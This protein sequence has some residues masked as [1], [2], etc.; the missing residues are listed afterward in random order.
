MEAREFRENWEFSWSPFFGPFEKTT[1]IPPVRFTNCT[2]VPGHASLHDSLQIFSVRIKELRR[3]LQWPIHVFG[4]IAARDTIDQNRIIVFN[5]TRDN[6]Q[7]LTK[8]DRYLSLTGPT[9]AV[10]ATDNV[11]LEAVLKVK[12][13]IESEDK[14]LSFLTV[15]LIRTFQTVKTC[16]VNREYTSRLSTMELTFGYVVHS[17]EAAISVHVID[18]LW[19]DGYRGLFA[20]H[21]FSLKDSKVVLLDCGY[22]EMVPVNADGRIG[23]SRHVVSVESKGD[24]TVSVMA[25]G[26]DDVKEDAK[27]FTPKDAGMSCDVLDVGFCK[28]EVTVAWSLISLVPHEYIAQCHSGG[29]EREAQEEIQMTEKEAGRKRDR[30]PGEG[31]GGS[32]DWK[33]EER[34][35]AAVARMKQKA[36]AAEWHRK[37]REESLKEME[38]EMAKY[39][40][41]A[42]IPPV[43]YTHCKD[44]PVPRHI[45]LRHTLQIISV[46]VKGLRRGLQW[47]INVFGLIAARDT[48]DRNRIMIFDRTRDNCQT[49]TKEDQYLLLTGP[50]RAVVVSDPVYFEAA[51]KVKGSIESEDK[52]LSFLAVSLTGTSESG[53]TCLVNR[54]Y[55]SRLPFGILPIP[56]GNLAVS[57]LVFGCG[58]EIK[59]EKDFTPEE[60]G[61]SCGVL[62]VGFCKMEVTTSLKSAPVL[63]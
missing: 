57:V 62:D 6:C 33:R 40:D 14:D 50:T 36:A 3:G 12:G 55:T 13:S 44:D 32:L 7:T 37:A 35:A 9:R 45:S 15:S 61:M 31:E 58:D 4:L 8:E 24:L 2:P 59:A 42:P 63:G 28:M 23:L 48:I 18:G 16:L 49:L 46:K 21:T 34:D 1:P 26:C 54:E 39:P 22:D 60:V 38:R 30:E 29:M 27:D 53:E 20:A 17:L 52:D 43:R 41:E 25:F 10:V 19:Q 11:H 56:V 5:H 51:L 47:P